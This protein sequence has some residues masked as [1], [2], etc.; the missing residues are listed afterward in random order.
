MIAALILLLGM[1]APAPLQLY[2]AP[3][4]SGDTTQ[5]ATIEVVLSLYSTSEARG[6]TLDAPVPAGLRLIS[7]EA[8]T[9]TVGLDQPATIRLRYFV[10]APNDGRYIPLRYVA[11][12]ASCTTA[13]TA[14]R[15]GSVAWPAAKAAHTVYAPLVAK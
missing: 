7:T 10:L 14:I 1:L 3:Y 13:E 9:D 8:N 15:V 5:G 12:A 4:P 6:F 2:A 11:C